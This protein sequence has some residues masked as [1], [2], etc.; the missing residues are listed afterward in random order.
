MTDVDLRENTVKS[1]S[2]RRLFEKNR[3]VY[4]LFLKKIYSSVR[5]SA[6]PVMT[7][8]RSARTTK[9]AAEHATRK[10]EKAIIET[11]VR[12]GR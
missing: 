6:L 4:N 10:A 8:N 2:K 9:A 3:N 5:L 7:T 11:T 1:F 12:A